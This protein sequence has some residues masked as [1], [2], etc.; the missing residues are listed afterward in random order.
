MLAYDDRV[1]LLDD[2]GQPVTRWDSETVKRH[3][4]TGEPVPDETA[5]VP[6]YEYVKPRKAE[7]PEVEFVVGNPP[8]VGNKRM[9][10]ELGDGYVEALRKTHSDVPE[11]AD[12]V[13]YWW[14]HAATLVRRGAIQRFGLI[15]TNSVTQVFNR[16]VLQTHLNAENP[17]SIMFAV[18]DHP[19]VDSADGAAVRVAMTTGA[20]GS[21]DG[22]LIEVVDEHET[23]EGAVDVI[24][25]ERKGRI[26]GRFNDRPAHD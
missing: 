18:P 4:V 9:R 8:F 3:P 5:R 21:F 17:L 20:R 1:P 7:W 13:M 24:L 19:W 10:I 2:T 11:T 15:T 22:Q 14:N 25:C 16:K 26:G 6:V 12:Y 23:G